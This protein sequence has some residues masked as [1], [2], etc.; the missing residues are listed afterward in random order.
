MTARVQYRENAF[1]PLQ[2]RELFVDPGET[3]EVLQ[4]QTPFVIA[5]LNGKPLLRRDGGWRYGLQDGD[6]LIFVTLPA[7]GGRGGGGGGSDPMRVLLTVALFSFA[8]GLA[9][10][11][12][13]IAAGATGVQGMLLAGTT[14]GIQMAG[15]A[16]IN[17]LMPTPKTANL[18]AASPTYTLQAQG[19][20]ARIGQ[21]IPV[22][23]GRVLSYPDFAAQPYAEFSGS[24]QY[25]YQ[26]LCLGL[27]E[28]EIEDIRIEDTSIW[29][30]EEVS[31]QVVPPGGQVTLFPT[32][33][34]T[35]VEVSGQELTGTRAGT[36]TR[37]GTTVTVTLTAHGFA[38]G[39]AKALTFT[40]GGG[41]TDVYLVASVLSADTFTVTTPAVGTSG[42]VTVAEVVG[43]IDGFVASAAGTVAYRLGIDLVLPLGLYNRDGSGNL[44]AIS[45]SHQVQVR[46]VDDF[47]APLGPWIALEGSP[48]TGKTV[49]PLRESRQ[50][51]LATPGRYRVRAFRTNALADPANNAN[52]LLMT[53]LRA[54]LAEPTDR[55]PVTLIAVRMRATN[56]LSLQASRK[57]GVIATRKVPVWNGT[58][59]SA[60]VATNSIAWAIADAARNADYGAGL[61]DSRLRLAK[62]LALDATWTARMDTFNGRFDSTQGWWD[63]IRKIAKAG[64]AEP[65][66][67]GGVLD[68]V[69]DDPQTVPVALFSMRNIVGDTF[70]IDYLMQ[71]ETSSDAVSLGYF[72][73]VTW[74]PQRVLALLP[75]STGEKPAKIDR[76]GIDNR[77]QAIREAMYEAACNRYRRRIVAFATEMEG[78][79]PAF[80]DLIAIQHDMVGWGGFGEAVGW[81]P[82][83]RTLTLSEPVTVSAGTV[84]G[85]RKAGG[86]L[87]GPWAVSAGPDAYNVILAVTPDIVPEVRGQDRERTHV[88]FG[89]TTTWVTMAK[90]LSARPSDLYHVTIQAV[91]E[92]PSVHTAETGIV[93]PPIVTSSLPRQ[94]TRPIVTGLF[95]TRIPGNATR[96]VIGWQPAPGADVYHVEM[97]EGADVN[98]P[99]AFWTRV[100]DTS[101]ATQASTLLHAARTMIRVRGVGLAAGPW[102]AATLG[103]LIPGFWL[104][105]DTP[106]WGADSDPFWSY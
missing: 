88:V 49:T 97:A 67:Q 58:S 40:S 38:S 32:A 103:S 94:V 84:I 55:G 43:G 29:T 80:G 105:D 99:Q 24:D 23:Y 3:V 90:V 66:M 26:L 42:A 7:G 41:V 51:T 45:V 19:N 53:G 47:G 12:T 74:A 89:T 59:W 104:S 34:E 28:Y 98:D 72:D 48:I 85:L 68:V 39:Q 4:P 1:A 31:V 2:Q 30:F 57:I 33:V 10:Q 69:R 82:A 95:A 75:G 54:Y 76:F 50:Y 102:T 52:Q 93:A 96:C 61:P 83:T 56:N 63:A 60:P 25:L 15:S 79:I 11:I 21:A 6:D 37:S 77:P 27:G 81:N 92:D 18:P 5:I 8:P 35:S 20:A 13:S 17:A 65:V 87:S 100:A 70:S 73:W 9:T 36:W 62:L 22:Q 44:N 106:F 16:L 78:F 86:G 101:A 14:F 91:T 64:R 46:L 71:S